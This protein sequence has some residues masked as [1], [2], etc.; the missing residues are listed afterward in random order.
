MGAQI[1]GSFEL[2]LPQ[3]IKMTMTRRRERNNPRV[4]SD[5]TRHVARKVRVL[6]SI[7][8]MLRPVC[9]FDTLLHPWCASLDE[10]SSLC[11][12]EKKVT[13]CGW[14]LLDDVAAPADA[15][16]TGRGVE[17][18]TART[19]WLRPLQLVGPGH[20][21]IGGGLHCCIARTWRWWRSMV[22]TNPTAH[23][24]YLSLSLSLFSTKP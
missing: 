7:S 3:A 6:T 10:K 18:L 11:E 2:Q 20:S 22:H 4:N 9:E 16:K 12:E 1:W 15:C 8:S 24:H 21:P 17:L 23:Y 19:V 13:L 14:R 5:V